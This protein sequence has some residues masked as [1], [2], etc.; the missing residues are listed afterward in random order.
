MALADEVFARIRSRVPADDPRL[1]VHQTAFAK[2]N[3]DAVC[4]A[5]TPSGA[6]RALVVDVTGHGL[7]AAL[8]TLPIVSL[9]HLLTASCQPLET[10]VAVLNRE[11]HAM[12]PPRLFAAAVAWELAPDGRTLSVVNAGMPSLFV[13][14]RA[15]VFEC[16]SHAVPLGIVAPHCPPVD[17]VP[18]ESGDVVFALSDG[19]IERTA[20]C[21][22]L[23][24]EGRIRE[25]LA[26]T[27]REQVFDTVLRLLTAYP[28]FADDQTLLSFTV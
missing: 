20:A 25:L 8:G 26:G 21:G 6:R 18:V 12:L 19:I 9:F 27:P 1:R 7:T 5:T 17:R 28:C 24:G 13:L 22:T 2:F 4:V 14:G 23:L 3:G 15:G 16:S 10:T 11:L